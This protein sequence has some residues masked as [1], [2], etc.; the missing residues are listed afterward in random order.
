MTD[1]PEAKA[2]EAIS[3]RLS[4]CRKCPR[5]QYDCEHQCYPEEFARANAAHYLP[6]LREVYRQL[7][8]MKEAGYHGCDL[9]EAIEH[10]EAEIDR[11]ENGSA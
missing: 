10:V 7:I 2:A 6:L 3:I 8:D 9:Y 11:L 5:Y 1:G 4:D